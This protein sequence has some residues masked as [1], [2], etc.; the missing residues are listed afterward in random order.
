MECLKRLLVLYDDCH[1]TSSLEVRAEMEALYLLLGLGNNQTLN[2]AL[3]L[4]GQLR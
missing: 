2:R 1:N 4:S 3:H